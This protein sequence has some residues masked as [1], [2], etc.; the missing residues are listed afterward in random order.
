MILSVDRLYIDP[1]FIVSTLF[2]ES[3]PVAV[4]KPYGATLIILPRLF[5]FQRKPLFQKNTVFNIPFCYMI[6]I[7][8]YIGE[9]DLASSRRESTVS[10]CTKDLRKKL[11]HLK[12]N[13]MRFE[14]IHLNVYHFLRRG[15]K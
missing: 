11:L 7:E 9:A 12:L 8:P 13:K 10:S 2:F 14:I 1:L 5:P 3:G 6:Q 15:M 4:L